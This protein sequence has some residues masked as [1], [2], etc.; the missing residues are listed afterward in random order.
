MSA[1]AT[2]C[3][4]K[5]YL[6]FFKGMLIEGPPGPSG[7]AV[8]II[9]NSEFPELVWWWSANSVLPFQGL[10]G[11]AGLQGPPGASGDPG[12]RVSLSFMSPN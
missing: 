2:I 1:H 12:D 10:P 11:P 7:P 6:C 3:D 5:H 9:I 8:S 4:V